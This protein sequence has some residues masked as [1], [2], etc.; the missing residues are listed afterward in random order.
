MEHEATAMPH[1]RMVTPGRPL[2]I[3]YDG[4]GVDKSKA[5]RIV[6]KS[7]ADFTAIKLSRT[8]SASAL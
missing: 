4:S 5:A 3:V 8:V 2:H 6:Q 1:V 7:F